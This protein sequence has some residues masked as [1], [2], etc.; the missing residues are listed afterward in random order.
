MNDK[1]TA[2]GV[3]RI[4]ELLE[5]DFANPEWPDVKRAL[6]ELLRLREQGVAR[7][8]ENQDVALPQITDELFETFGGIFYLIES[9]NNVGRQWSQEAVDFASLLK[10]TAAPSP[11]CAEPARDTV[12]D[13]GALSWAEIQ[14]AAS[15]SKWIPAQ[16]MANDWVSDVCDFLR[17]GPRC[18]P[19]AD[20]SKAIDALVGDFRG[21][22]AD[23]KEA[24][25]EP[26]KV[27]GDE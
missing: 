20:A 11:V 8:D 12:M 24:A 18:Q 15:E 22:M 4:R 17:N 13:L 5:C 27:C 1:L 7:R 9:H 16:Y 14:K 25:A 19:A 26:A 6:S 3:E 21:V 2:V 23:C 10:Q